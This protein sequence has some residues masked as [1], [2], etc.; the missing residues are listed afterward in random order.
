M[1]VHLNVTVGG[2]G[3]WVATSY[4]AGGSERR[5][6]PGMVV[7]GVVPRRLPWRFVGA[8]VA[9]QVRAHAAAP[10]DP[11]GGGYLIRI[12]ADELGEYGAEL[13]RLAHG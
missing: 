7:G 10:I 12:P 2:S 1:T 13:V 5:L 9:R 4:T 11:P 6:P 3:R 8:E